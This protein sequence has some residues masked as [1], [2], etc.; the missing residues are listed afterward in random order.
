VARCVTLFIVDVPRSE[1]TKEQ[2]QA[3]KASGVILKSVYQSS[4]SQSGLSLI[5]YAARKGERVTEKTD[6]TDAKLQTKFFEGSR[7]FL[8]AL[9]NLRGQ[10]TIRDLL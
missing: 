8:E 3:L 5:F 4:S 9:K 6:F 2:K 10:S 7:D 1:P